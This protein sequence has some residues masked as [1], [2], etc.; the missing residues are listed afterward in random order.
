LSAHESRY[1][2]IQRGQ[3]VTDRLEK[4]F[5]A[6]SKLPQREQDALADWLIEEIAAERRWEELLARSQ[7]RVAEMADEALKEYRERRTKKLNPDE[8]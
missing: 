8:L 5:A 7:D 6:A 4:A 2:S 3:T 1:T